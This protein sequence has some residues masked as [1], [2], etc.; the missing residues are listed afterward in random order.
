MPKKKKSKP[1]NESFHSQDG[2]ADKVRKGRQEQ[3]DELGELMRKLDPS[4]KT[5]RVER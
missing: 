3:V 5:P 4:I 2:K 1:F